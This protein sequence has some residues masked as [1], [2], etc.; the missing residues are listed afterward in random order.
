[1]HFV[2]NVMPRVGELHSS[3]AQS[4]IRNIF[5][6]HVI[7][8]GRFASGSDI[9]ERV[10]MPTPAAVLSAAELVAELGAIDPLL[11]RPVI[12]DVGGATTDVYS[13]IGGEGA[14]RGYTVRSIPEQVV[15]RT[16]EGDLGMRESVASLLEAARLE[17]YLTACN[18]RDLEDPVLAR[19]Q[20]RG[21]LPRAEH[22]TV[23][24]ETLATMAA[25]IALHRHAGVLRT[26]LSPAGVSLQKTG[27]D[28]REASCLILTGGVFQHTTRP[29][30]LGCAA[31]SAA[32][33]RGAL[34][35]KVLPVVRDRS[36]L[37]WAGGLLRHTDPRLAVKLVENTLEPV[38]STLERLRQ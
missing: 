24:D 10:K 28:L 38:E 5:I 2:D 4:A 35:P 29:G 14:A 25:A 22:E 36:Y 6:E 12:V 11:A 18:A 27:R 26:S 32:R 34:L 15:T 30:E 33:T 1:V 31:I 9:A 16:V 17:R 19:S 37:M 7:G 3:A 20:E 13:V 21:F 8:R 23:V